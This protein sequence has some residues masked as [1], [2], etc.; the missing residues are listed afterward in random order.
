MG[1]RGGGDVC[2]DLPLLPVRDLVCAT[3]TGRKEHAR[4]FAQPL[5]APGVGFAGG[6]VKSGGGSL[7]PASSPVIQQSPLPSLSPGGE[8]QREALW[9]V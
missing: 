2:Q 3:L 4:S 9:L 7:S 8:G 5:T 6:P 1:G